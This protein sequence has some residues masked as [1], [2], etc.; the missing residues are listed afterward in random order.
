MC[1]IRTENGYIQ[2]QSTKTIN[3][4]VFTLI[5]DMENFYYS[6]NMAKFGMKIF[7]LGSIILSGHN[8]SE[9]KT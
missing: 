5:I 7:N 9:Q 6:T 8:F 3:Y 2:E 4:V 1:Y